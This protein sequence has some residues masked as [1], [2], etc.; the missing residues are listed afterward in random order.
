MTRVDGDTKFTTFVKVFVVSI[1]VLFV[2]SRIAKCQETHKDQTVT[3]GAT[4]G[5]DLTLSQEVR[6]KFFENAF[7]QQTLAR[8]ND[9][10]A[11]IFAQ[12]ELKQSTLAAEWTELE[13]KTL[14]E[15]KLDPKVYRVDFDAESNLSVSKIP[16]PEA[17]Q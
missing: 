12:N 7:K 2:L 6:V 15:M 9:K 1:L 17:K 4:T 5:F 8:Q 13:K 16:L 10:L 11:K 3:K 14:Q